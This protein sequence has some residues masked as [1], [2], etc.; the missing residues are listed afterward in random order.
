MVKFVKVTIHVTI[1]AH[2]RLKIFKYFTEEIRERNLNRN[3]VATRI[4][5]KDDYKHPYCMNSWYFRIAE[6]KWVSS[7]ESLSYRASKYL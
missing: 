4:C 3:I 1:H 2:K 5:I 7:N 6:T